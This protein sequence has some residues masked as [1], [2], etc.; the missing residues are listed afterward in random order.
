MTSISYGKDL[1]PFGDVIDGP[2]GEPIT[3]GISVAR[4]NDQDKIISPVL[5]YTGTLHQSKNK[6]YV[7]A[8]V[9]ESFKQRTISEDSE[10]IQKLKTFPIIRSGKYEV[11]YT[12]YQDNDY[13]SYPMGGYVNNPSA[14][15]EVRDYVEL[16]II[17]PTQLIVPC[18][19]VSNTSISK[20]VKNAIG[21]PFD[22]HLKDIKLFL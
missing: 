17:D 6:E 20:T 10:V 16:P 9:I 3:I 4:L 22:I 21:K 2:D 5:L 15:V 13:E 1:Y 14:V 19:D 18:Y 8:V 12:T 7:A 11:F